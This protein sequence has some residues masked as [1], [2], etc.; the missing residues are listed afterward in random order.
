LQRLFAAQSA[1]I[2]QE[3]FDQH[4]HLIGKKMH[5]FTKKSTCFLMTAIAVAMT[6]NP[7][8]TL[9]GESAQVPLTG[10]T[11]APPKISDQDRSSGTN[12]KLDDALLRLKQQQSNPVPVT[13]DSNPTGGIQLKPGTQPETYVTVEIV[14][15][16]DPAAVQAQLEKIGFKT[17]A[18][19]HNH[20]SGRLP[21]S[22]IKAA[23]DLTNIS[24]I[25]KPEARTKTGKVNSQGDLAQGSKALRDSYTGTM[26]DANGNVVPILGGDGITIGVISDTFNCFQQKKKAG[27]KDPEGDVNDTQATD[28][29]SSDLPAGV[30]IVQEGGCDYGHDEGRAMAQIIH[31]VAPGA[32]IAFYGPSS[33]ADMAQGILTLSMPTTQTD[34]KG[35]HGAGAKIVVD[36]LGWSNESPYDAGIIGQ[37]IDEAAG[38]YGIAYFSAAGNA[39]QPAYDNTN[40]SFA[41]DVV[42]KAKN[43]TSTPLNLNE[44]LLNFDASA[45]TTINNLPLKLAASA[46]GYVNF[47]EYSVYWDQSTKRDDGASSS[48]NVCIA[49]RNGNPV[50]KTGGFYK[51]NAAGQFY[52]VGSSDL[53]SGAVPVGRPA[54][55]VVGGGALFYSGLADDFTLRLSL[56]NKSKAPSRV[57]IFSGNNN[58]TISQFGTSTGTILGHPLSSNAFAVGAADYFK[59]PYCDSALKTAI[60]EDFSS[61]G[62]TPVLFNSDGTI[63]AKPGIP[64]KP[65]FVAPDGAST[66]FFGDASRNVGAASAKVPG[67]LG[68]DHHFY[69]TSAAAPHA[70]A[71]TAIAWEIAPKFSVS[72]LSKVLKSTAVGMDGGAFN[73]GSG[74]L[75]GDNLL[76]VESLMNYE[77]IN[78]PLNANNPY[79]DPRYH[80]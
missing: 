22:Q 33:P 20:I 80:R 25:S 40:A 1:H 26:L 32:K 48:I 8:T 7:V 47:V 51:K 30:N 66:T 39:G 27:L 65:D 71:L 70:A 23:A 19:F 10:I 14:V 63:K 54:Q 69:G 67:C 49:D 41:V 60:L 4:F 3:L 6:A 72:D 77:K 56:A 9:A 16:D 44:R 64:A 59:T 53:C 34:A 2:R 24:T 61:S 31:D 58:L 76:K 36:D 42:T 46:A 79:N 74:F 68:T 73:V 35:R 37:A 15:K 12:A 52:Q 5:S 18:V 21:V 11:T 38:K 13:K 28:V 62:G 17:D 45:R 43:A 57:H 78:G 55:I 29:T 50:A 75:K